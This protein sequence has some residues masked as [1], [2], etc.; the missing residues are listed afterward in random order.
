MS[1]NGFSHGARAT[2]G[3]AWMS[4][5]ACAA[6]LAGR[7][8]SHDRTCGLVLSAKKRLLTSFP[9]LNES[10]SPR[11]MS[12]KGFSHGARANERPGLPVPEELRAGASKRAQ[13]AQRIWQ[14]SRP[15]ARTWVASPHS[16][17]ANA[18]ANP[19]PMLTCAWAP[20]VQPSRRPRLGDRRVLRHSLSKL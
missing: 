9:D 12:A 18:K 1:A 10:A 4:E 11:Q 19:P 14:E 7:P 6:N 17:G 20:L 13:R 16:G 5:Q 15:N 2:S 8:L 3:L